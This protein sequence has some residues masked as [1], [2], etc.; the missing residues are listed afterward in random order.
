M[1]N[2]Q[3][4]LF[5]AERVPQAKA[6]SLT[7]RSRPGERLTPAQR[8]FNRLT[9]QL[10]QLRGRLEKEMR[11][12][13]KALAYYGEHLHPRL[14]RCAALRKEI[15]RV[16]A[17]FLD[18]S[19]IKDKRDRRALRDLIAEQLNFILGEDGPIE[20]ADLRALFKKVHGTTYESLERQEVD[21]V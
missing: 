13:D 1:A 18:S 6:V 19:L 15:V 2:T 4:S 11:R 14:R 5:E 3:K 9:A 17:P 21:E 10:E 12:L 7:L 8:T 20:D 16:M